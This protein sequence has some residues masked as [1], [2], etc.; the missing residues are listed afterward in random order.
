MNIIPSFTPGDNKLSGSI[1]G[2]TD[3]TIFSIYQED[4]YDRGFDIIIDTTNKQL[5]FHPTRTG[6]R[7]YWNTT[8]IINGVSM[9]DSNFFNAGVSDI[10]FN[11]STFLS[12]SAIQQLDEQGDMQ[13]LTITALDDIT[14]SYSLFISIWIQHMDVGSR[15]RYNV[16]HWFFKGL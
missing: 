1:D 5:K 9:S 6:N 10:Y 12:P 11:S 3:P 14:S 13:Y 2:S 8:S 7:V 4:R 16:S 15:F